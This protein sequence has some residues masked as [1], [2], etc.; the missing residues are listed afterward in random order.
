MKVAEYDSDILENAKANWHYAPDV[1]FSLI[2]VIKKH[3]PT[4]YFDCGTIRE[5]LVGVL[6]KANP[7]MLD[8]VYDLHDI[9]K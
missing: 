6:R 1:Y 5:S 2:N 9:E 8:K 4:A 3:G 7:K